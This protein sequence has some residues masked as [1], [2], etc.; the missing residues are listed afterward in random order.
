VESI[1]FTLDLFLL[2]LAVNGLKKKGIGAGRAKDPD[3]PYLW[4]IPHAAE[5][6]RVSG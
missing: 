4:E 5:V 1:S 3:G 6:R 2:K